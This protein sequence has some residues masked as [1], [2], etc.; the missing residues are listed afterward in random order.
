MSFDS[1]VSEGDIFDAVALTLGVGC[2][3]V[4]PHFNMNGLGKGG[5]A[6]D[7]T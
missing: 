4:V 5:G 7:Q 1:D 3:F 6:V 2:V